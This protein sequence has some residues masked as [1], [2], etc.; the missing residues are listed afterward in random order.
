ME[1]GSCCFSVGYSLGHLFRLG[2]AHGL[3]PESEGFP[4]CSPLYQTQQYFWRLE[5]TW[6]SSAFIYPRQNSALHLGLSL[7]D[8]ADDVI[9]AASDFNFNL[10][11]YHGENPTQFT[12]SNN[13]W[14]L[15]QSIFVLLIDFSYLGEAT[16]IRSRIKTCTICVREHRAGAS[17][18]SRIPAKG[19]T[20]S[21]GGEKHYYNGWNT[22]SSKHEI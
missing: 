9:I 15:Q 5:W 8:D 1:A 13:R 14:R 7:S 20:K 2:L 3:Y 22:T 4:Q 17:Y 12:N 21:R 19:L 18:G 6:V 16:R 10:H 11:Q